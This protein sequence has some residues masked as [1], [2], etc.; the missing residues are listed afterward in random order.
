M[1]VKERIVLLLFKNK[2]KSYSGNEVDRLR[3]D[4]FAL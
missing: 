3:E 4:A 1:G 2:R